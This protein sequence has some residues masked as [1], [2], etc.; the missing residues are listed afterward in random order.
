MRGESPSGI[1]GSRLHSWST[2]QIDPKD[3]FDC[4]SRAEGLSGVTAELE[5]EQRPAFAGEFLLRRIGTASLIE[6]RAPRCAVER[7]ADDNANAPGDSLCIYQQLGAGSRFSGNPEFS[8]HRGMFATV[9][10]DLPYETAALAADGFHLRILKV[11]AADLRPSQADLVKAGLGDLVPKPF[12]ERGALAPLLASCFR[13][14]TETDDASEPERARSL[15]QALAQLALIERGLIRPGSRTALHALRVGR[16]SLAR[17][18]IARNISRAALSPAMVADL[19][20][21]S[22][23]HLHILFEATD[24]SFA[25]TV[26]A[27]RLAESRRLLTQPR[28]QSISDIALACGFNSIATFYRAFQAAHGMSPGEF[29]ATQGGVRIAAATV[30]LSEATR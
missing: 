14:L 11:P 27:E 5:P 12:C 26:T 19:L 6:L 28:E 8:I 2:D 1:D 13:D 24:I 16:L 3:R 20:G 17:R 15:V 18:L 10:S 21:I 9:Y 25:Q 4:W 7:S 22:V 30:D 29:R 23:R